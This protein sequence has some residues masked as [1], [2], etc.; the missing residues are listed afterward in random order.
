MTEVEVNGNAYLIGRIDA[1]K[2]LHVSRRVMPVLVAAGI[3]IAEIGSAAQMSEAVLLRLADKALDVVSKMSDADFEYVV[4]AALGV[5][6][7][8]PAGSQDPWAPVMNGSLFQFGDMDQRTIIQVSI[9]SLRENMG[10]FFQP[11]PDTTSTPAG[12]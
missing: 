7:R 8:R 3:S 12:S 5:V 11:A 9:A 1:M 4:R 6:K 2:Q 10:G